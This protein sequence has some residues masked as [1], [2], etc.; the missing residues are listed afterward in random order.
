MNTPAPAAPRRGALLLWLLAMAAGLWMV[1]RAQYTAD[2]SAF[3]PKSPD[4]DQR[5]L[6]E[7]LQSG[8]AARTLMIGI[9]GGSEAQRAQASRTLAAA[10]RAGGQ[11][12]QVNNGERQDW[13]AAGA[14]MLQHRYQLSPAVDA[15][16]FT[17]AGLREAVGDTL[18]TLG[19]PAGALARPLLER[20][21]TGEV[22][23]IA[24]SLIPANSPRSAQGVWVSRTAP[25]A[26]LLGI[27]KAQGADLDGQQRAIAAVRTAFEPLAA[28]GLVLKVSGP[29]TFATESRAR[30]EGEAKALAAVGF[31]VIGG[32]MLVAFASL[33]AMAVAMLPVATGVVAGIA[34]VSVVFG[35]VH[36]LTLGFGS[37]LIGEAV[38]YAIYYLIQAHHGGWRAWRQQSWPTVRLGMLTS[39]CGF[40]ALVFSGF[41]GLAQLGLF[42]VAGLAAAAFATRFVLPVVVPQGAPGLGLRRR[43]AHAGARL[44]ALLPRLRWGVLAL[45][46]ITVGVLGAHWDHLWR[47]NLGSLSP[48]ATEA[49]KLDEAL[50][51]DL[52]ASDARVLVVASGASVEAALQAA[53][54][55]GARLDA[56][57]ADG[58][59]AGYDSPARLLPSLAMQR[60]RQA[61][62]PDDATL[63]ERTAKALAGGPLP[64]ARLEPFFADVQAARR[65]P[66]LTPEAIAATPLKPLVDAMLF[67]RQ[68]GGWSA[69]LPL[70][71]SAQGI[72]AAAIRAAL[73][74]AGGGGGHGV[75]SAIQVVD[76]K[77]SLDDLY[78]R[79]LHEALVQALLGALAVVLL[80][81]LQLRSLRRLLGVCLPLALSVLLTM[82]LLAAAGVALGILHLVGL[83]LVVAVGSNYGLFFDQWQLQGTPDEDTLASLLLA[84]ITTVI[85]FGLIALSAIPALSAIGRVVAPG[86]LLALLLSAVFSRALAP[87]SRE[88]RM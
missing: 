39:V 66:P 74:G 28:Q 79:Y 56:L 68:Q 59:I 57:A 75:T 87:A 9:D 62:L 2:L 72:D 77:Q 11:F 65:L 61:A 20:D 63:R 36:G 18:A 16:H 34:A 55:A 19:T 84:N 6:I 27:T 42:S 15:Q 69:L 31:V 24:E 29:A 37:T 12:E 33:R 70:T 8:I 38:D 60:A 5:V 78:D 86:A 22:Q 46:G 52:G 30:I 21:P 83:L 71:P 49:Q 67:A 88:T 26:L 44:F 14:L 23:R 45:A 4:A 40:G 3:L 82:G 51:A 17:E 80:M 10:L 48:V 32:L 1:A 53:E 64:V 47:G 58:R 25:R 35:S 54:R 7:Q 81:A 13:Q 50:R 73:Q 43:L 41:P 76:I 85:A